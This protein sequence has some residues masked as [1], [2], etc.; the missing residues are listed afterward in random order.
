MTPL[1]LI[2]STFCI[3]VVVLLAAP[4]A[5][6][7]KPASSRGAA[8]NARPAPQQDDATL[9]AVQFVGSRTG[10]AAG[11]HGTVWKSDDGGQSWSLLPTPTSAS[12]RSLCFLTAQ[13]GWVA[14]RSTQAFTGVGAGVL[15]RTADG[16]RSWEEPV[17]NLP[18]LNYVRFFGTDDG[19]A[20]GEASPQFPTGVLVTHDGGDSWEAVEG[21]QSAGW[22]AADFFELEHGIVAGDRGRLTFAA[23][24][25]V[26]KPRNDRRSLRSVRAVDLADG[27][28]GWAV[29]D[30][31]LVL[32]TGNGGV[33]WESPPKEF[34]Q[35]LSTF[36]D[37]RAVAAKGSKVWLTGSPGGRI[38]SS[39][40]AG[41]HWTMQATGQ[42]SPLHALCFQSE[43]NGWAVGTFGTI[44]RTVDGGQT[45]ETARAGSR[46]AALLSIH[47]RPERLP[48]N[49]LAKYSN[50]QGF[51][52]VA[53]VLPKWELA[54]DRESLGPFERRANDA[55]LA[56][57]GN[58]ASLGWRLPI[59]L[60]ELDRN[61]DRLTE[62]WQKQTEGR[63]V[64]VVLSSLVAEL[65][66]WRPSVVVIDQPAA[67]DAVGKLVFEAVQRAIP[68]AADPTRFLEHEQLGGLAAW[69]VERVFV[70][71]D[72][73][74]A[75]RVIV[76]PFEVLPRLNSTVHQSA[77][78]GRSML[79]PT[80]KQAPRR[81]SFNVLAESPDDRFQLVAA[82][83]FWTG[84]AIAAGS[85]ARRELRP[86][87]EKDFE[88]QRQ[89]ATQQRNFRGIV[90]QYLDDPVRANSMIAEL[91]NSVAGLTKSQAALQHMQLADDFRRRS[92][93]DLAEATLIEVVNQYQSEPIAAEAMLWLL[94]LWSSEEVSWQRS[95]HVSITAGRQT[96]DRNAILEKMHKLAEAVGQPQ[97][98]PL[99][100][101]RETT[102][103]PRKDVKTIESS[104]TQDVGQQRS[105]VERNWQLQA[106]QMARI[107][108]QRHPRLYESPLVQFPLASALRQCGQ[109]RLADSIL[110]KFAQV[111]TGGDPELSEAGATGFK[112]P[113]MQRAAAELWMTTPADEIPRTF[114]A[115]KLASV[116]PHLDG[117]LSDDCWREA[118]E[119]RLTS[120][121]TTST[122]VEAN[123]PFALLSYDEQ[124]LYIAASLPRLPGTPT[125]GPNYP[126][127][128]HDADL[129]GFDRITVQLDV[130][131]DYATSYAIHV[132]QRGQVAEQ[133]WED[134]R[135][136]PKLFVAVEGEAK[137]WRLEMAIPF[138]ELTA[139]PPRQRGSWA[140]SINRTTPLVGTASWPASASDSTE[141]PFG[142]VQ[143][144]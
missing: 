73:K 54:G 6:Q 52:S 131:R 10:W 71:V 14:G 4:C 96:T 85:D 111:K 119:L 136:N 107:L 78:S 105:L 90:D 16:G 23:D 34:P 106:V 41:H 60:P 138:S 76:D 30:G 9:H 87:D 81:E 86:W 40:D 31:G 142:L 48:F 99:R 74:D 43:D 91:R 88:K 110:R 103:D 57:G 47:A 72:P 100:I 45:W 120:G 129:S 117:V 123:Y 113:L 135:W 46:R 140:I 77:M 134:A 124:F 62:E 51:R 89:L 22:L 11:D 18:P 63:L 92:N 1:N 122:D 37:F 8:I 33:S 132:D 141:P 102:V 36:A 143:F 69:K 13:V 39:L 26:V 68:V 42:T 126:G 109:L 104:P 75:G 15:L 44:L 80:F 24:L 3:V 49:A 67:D 21:E 93:W 94:R 125:D 58:E 61:L 115:A 95:R 82:R 2:R 137:H 108:R 121:S 139:T 127:R 56:V 130:N 59:A 66:Q 50:E 83:E 84:I 128:T 20:V 17:E 133:C 12:L 29:G 144:R 55:L 118:R 114:T 27:L 65:R 28:N 112:N 5:A 64:D 25:N 32:K 116:R 19:I 70:Q 98:D 7:S 35:E 97:D 38:W 79:F 53:I 101:A